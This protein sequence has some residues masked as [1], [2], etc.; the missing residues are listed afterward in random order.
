MTLSEA[1]WN[2]V[3]AFWAKHIEND[4]TKHGHEV[5]IRL[6]LE[7]KAAQNLFDKFRHL[8]S[9]AEMR[10]CADLQ[11]HGNTVFTALGKTLK[12][13][14]HHDADLRPMAE[15]HSHK[16]KIPVENFTLIC[17]I[18]DKYLHES[19]SDYTGDTRESL[20]SALGGVC[21]SLEKLYKEV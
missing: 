4:P 1:Q 16:H 2:N 3:L 7:S 21:H 10:S 15:S 11:K 13:K 18:I 6:F 12:L 5:L 8:G 14:G 19:F 20:K 9:E 17:S